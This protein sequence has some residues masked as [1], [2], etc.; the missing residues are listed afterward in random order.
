MSATESATEPNPPPDAAAPATQKR[1]GFVRRV[2]GLLFKGIALLIFLSLAA[3]AGL[4]WHPPDL[5]PH[6][7]RISRFLAERTGLA[8]RV[9][10]VHL[11]TGLS[12]ALVGDGVEVLCPVTGK[13]LFSVEQL[14]LRVS[15]LSW[16]QGWLSASL[17]V[18]GVEASAGRDEAGRLLL[19]GR[20]LDAF[21][22][23]GG[24]DEGVPITM[25][26]VRNATLNWV[27]PHAPMRTRMTGLEATAFLERDGSAHF[28][29]RAG[30]PEIHPQA[31]WSAKGERA[32]GDLWSLRARLE[33]VSLP[34]FAPYLVDLTP[35]DGLTAPFDLE[36]IVH[37]QPQNGLR[38]QWQ[39][40]LGAGSLAWPA[41]FRWPIPMTSLAA[42][43][44]LEQKGQAWHLRVD[45]F[46]LTS[47]H[48][49]AGGRL[50]L[51][52][53]GGSE[54]PRLDLTAEASGTRTEQAKYYFPTRIMHPDLVRWLDN[55][56]KEGQVTHATAH[57]KGP[58]NN[59]PAGPGDPPGEVFHIEGDVAGVTLHYHPPLMPLTNIATHLIF[60]R[61]G[62]TAQVASA[63]LGETRKVTGEVKI[64]NMQHNPTVEIAAESPALDLP[65]VW[66]GIVAHPALRWDRAVGMEQAVVQGQGA[67]T[68]KISLP[69]DH[70]EKMTYSGR[71]EW[72]KNAFRPPFLDT[73]VTDASGLL[74]LDPERL[75]I[76][77]LTA[78]LGDLPIS[79]QLAVRQYRTPGK[80]TLNARLE[81]R[82]EGERMAGTLAPWLGEGGTWQG[83]MPFW[84]EFQR[85]PGETRFLIKG[86]ADPA[87]VTV[88]GKMGWRKSSGDPGVVKGEGWLDRQGR[89]LVEPLRIELGNL[90]LAGQTDWNLDRNLGKITIRDGHLDQTSGRLALTSSRRPDGR[91]AWVAN[92]DLAT[93]D[94]RP[95][96][97]KREENDPP[98]PDPSPR[99]RWPR[100]SLA[101][102]AERMLLA[103]RE[104]ARQLEAR[105]EM[106]VRSLRFESLRFTQGEGEVE[107]NG[108]FLWSRHIDAGNYSGHLE[109]T[110]KDFGALL[111]GLDLYAGLDRG[112]GE[113]DVTLDGFLGP[114]QRLA[115]T[116]SGTA[117]FKFQEGKIRRLGFLSRLLGLFSLKELP[118]LVVGDRPDL[119]GTG[120]H[121]K[122]FQGTL[123]ISDN[124][125]N[126]DR[127][128]LKS[129]SM[130][131]VFTGKV[132]FPKDQ[133]DLLVGMRPLQTL[134]ALVT[135]V[136]LL[137]KLVTGDRQAVLETQFDVS[138]S[139]QDPQARIRPVTSLAPGLLRD[140]LA[141]PMKIFDRIKE[142][143]GSGKGDE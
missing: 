9:G 105:M 91:E 100:I 42:D 133:V 136:P 6:A 56:L 132:D 114:G 119:D 41:V 101:V 14:L 49:R 106:E 16:R 138:G 5:N 70:M 7:E 54:A 39:A 35:L 21:L 86:E 122:E 92:A 84:I 78:R 120:L 142:K 32:P 40:A 20:P 107:G 121:Y 66:K 88:R 130:N 68:M 18:E 93:L 99:E 103:N 8:I 45:R 30:L 126:I 48:G 61:H 113:L 71:L 3:L 55:H 46:D 79:G 10:G 58:V 64:A 52:G 77:R 15:P 72:K 27:D 127:M 131:I 76:S 80:A 109:M 28:D 53:L 4:A 75:E 97:E 29:A 83:A 110:A 98:P 44:V 117:R 51:D 112:G 26:T 128:W 13:P 34:L 43:G 50:T 38:V 116:L 85:P 124:V 115:D 62:M 69:L 137:G 33:R 95:L 19:A 73:P 67:A 123:S 57:I 82:L 87:G 59:I 47:P 129:P 125:W 63:V 102:Q 111:H 90:K 25:F 81:S 36:A 31:R 94:L 118:H 140:I 37:H 65:D 139:T 23:G 22:A 134:D 104:E 108:E 141:V 2:L 143:A 60:D 1:P 74:T 17:T 24:Q 135:G 96:L 89:L 12:L 11:R